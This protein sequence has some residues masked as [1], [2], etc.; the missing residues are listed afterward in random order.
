MIK[1]YCLHCNSIQ[2][3]DIA[4]RDKLYVK[5]NCAGCKE[6]I[7]VLIKSLKRKGWKND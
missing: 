7:S 3:I 5:G 2:E 1:F 6:P 4:F